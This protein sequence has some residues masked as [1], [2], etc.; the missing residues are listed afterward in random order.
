LESIE[1]LYTLK[2]VQN[3]VRDRVVPWIDFSAI[4]DQRKTEKIELDPKPN[5]RNIE[6]PMAIKHPRSQTEIVNPLNNQNKN[7]PYKT[8]EKKSFSLL[9]SCSPP[10]IK[11]EEIEY[12]EE[13]CETEEN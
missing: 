13:L 8:F 9:P 3:K 7:V 2:K 5:M 12:K 6:Q 4:N 10:R 11:E 1:N